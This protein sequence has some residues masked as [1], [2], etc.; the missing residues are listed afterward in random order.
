MTIINHPTFN[1]LHAAILAAE[2]AKEAETSARVKSLALIESTYGGETVKVEW[3]QLQPTTRRVF[4]FRDGGVTAAQKEVDRIKKQLREAEKLLK[5]AQEA[6]KAAGGARA[7]VTSETVSLR[8][9]RGDE[10]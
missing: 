6:A 2:A 9:V 7:R 8:V 1:K 3:G 5:G 10:G 4:T